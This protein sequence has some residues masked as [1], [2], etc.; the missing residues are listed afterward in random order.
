MFKIN[1]SHSHHNIPHFNREGEYMLHI[2]THSNQNLIEGN[3]F[4]LVFITPH[5]LVPQDET[6]KINDALFFFFQ[7]Q[8]SFKVTPHSYHCQTF[9]PQGLLSDPG[10]C[11]RSIPSALNLLSPPW[12]SLL[13]HVPSLLSLQEFWNLFRC[14]GFP[15]T[16]RHFSSLSWVSCNSTHLWHVDREI[17][18]EP[19]G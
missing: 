8:T 5:Y 6:R 12:T 19:T 18:S 2:N 10:H 13:F 17:T 3:K 11:S 9:A 16:T 15:Q 7:T 1:Y 4:I 14:L